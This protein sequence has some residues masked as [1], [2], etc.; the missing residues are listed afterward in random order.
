[1][2]KLPP[3]AIAALQRGSL[4]E[5]IKIVRDKTGMDL[6]SSKEAVERYANG[7]GTPADWQEGDWGRSEPE[8]AGMQGNGPA[9][10]PSAAL[11][12][13][14]KGNKI[15]AVGHSDEP[16]G[17]AGAGVARGLEVVAHRHRRPGRGAGLAVLR[18]GR[19]KR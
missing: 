4:I 3:E 15:E 2:D 12:A 9:A 13:L 1:M 18:E 7:E 8:G 11:T 19:L 14:A 6:K 17:R 16:D 5:A 10:V